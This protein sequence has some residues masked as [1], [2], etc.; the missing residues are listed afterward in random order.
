[1][2]FIPLGMKA[3][4]GYAIVDAA[5][6]W[7]D[8]YHWT[9]SKGYAVTNIEDQ[10]FALHSMVLRDVGRGVLVDHTDRNPRNN[11]R[12]NLRP[13]SKS[14]N[15]QNTGLRPNNRTGFKGVSFDRQTGRY[16]A[17]IKSNG[18]SV[19]L[20]RHDTAEDAAK[21]YDKAATA[22]FEPFAV[23]NFPAVVCV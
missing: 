22:A 2:A 13:A 20:G 11:R 19:N 3:K 21:A 9:V 7:L 8:R 10:S 16:R 1:M 4:Y 12:S 17:S 6:A 5:D 18:R 15:A 14:Q 23:L